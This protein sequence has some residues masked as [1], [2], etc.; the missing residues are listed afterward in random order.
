MFHVKDDFKPGA[1]VSA[2]PATWFNKVGAFLNNFVAGDG[3]RMFKNESGATVISLESDGDGAATTSYTTVKSG[4]SAESD[5]NTDKWT[6]GGT[7]GAKVSVCTLGYKK[8]D[9]NV[10]LRWRTLTISADGRITGISAED[11]GIVVYPGV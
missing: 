11:S 10:H 2:V 9:T 4:G 5:N 6:S 1:P 7:T 8:D 3:L